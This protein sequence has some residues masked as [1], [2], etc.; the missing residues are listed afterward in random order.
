M[1]PDGT[2]V[3]ATNTGIGSVSVISTASNTVIATTTVG[4]APTSLGDFI[5]AAALPVPALSWWAMVALAL[6]VLA[7]GAR[8][9]LGPQPG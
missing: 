7:L 3:Y 2:L 9:L 1:N 6:L 8:R 4:T 5:G